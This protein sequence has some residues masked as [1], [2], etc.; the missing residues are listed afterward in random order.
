MKNGKFLYS[1]RT[2]KDAYEQEVGYVQNAVKKGT[3]DGG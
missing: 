1:F 2:P 3:Y